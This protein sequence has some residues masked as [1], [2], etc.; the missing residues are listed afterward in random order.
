MP[1]PLSVGCVRLGKGIFKSEGVLEIP[2]MV[3]GSD[4]GAC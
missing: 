2:R 1:N 4:V 3:R